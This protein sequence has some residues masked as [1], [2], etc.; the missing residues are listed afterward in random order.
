MS[1]VSGKYD[2]IVIGSGFGGSVAAATLT[3]G[4]AKVLLLERGPWRDTKPVRDAGIEDRKPLPY[5]RHFYTHALS[6]LAAPFTRGM[7]WRFNC[8]GLF[9]LHYSPDMSVLCSSGVGGGS[10]VYAA[11]NERPEV[12]AYWDNR[13]QGISAE[14][15]ELH[16]C[17]MIDKMGG[18]S[19]APGYQLPNATFDRYKESSEFTADS[20]LP[21]PVMAVRMNGNQE[22]YKSNSFLGSRN[23]SKATLDRVLLLPALEKGL[24]VAARHECLAI[25]QQTSGEYLL[26]VLDHKRN[27]RCFIRCGKVILSAGTL[28]TVRL[29]SRSRELGGL[30]GMPALGLGFGGNGD[31][32]AYWAV[33]DGAVDY[34]AGIPY[35][36]RF[37][38]RDSHTG[39]PMPGPDLTSYGF[40]GFSDI[41]IPDSIR[42]RLKRNLL[43]VSMGADK[44]DGVLE[45]NKGK[46]RSKYL[47]QNSAILSQ[48][49]ATFDEIARR[50]KKAVFYSKKRLITVHPL[51]GARLSDRPETGVVNAQGEIYG[52]P[53]LYVA[54]AAALPAAPG[55][56]PSMTISAWSRHVARGI[57]MGLNRTENVEPIQQ[58][59]DA[60]G[61]VA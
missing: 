5:G 60:D 24:T 27:R 33:N 30:G 51:G 43:V 14:G 22:D 52:N 4:G 18:K 47:Q 58:A 9:D 3:D 13:A 15:M 46:L 35:H 21:Q 40:N 7:G 10:H 48:I 23:G 19:P 31:M 41:P 29:L 59:I 38:L 45:W 39:K 20:D 28:N 53:G 26:E 57:L 11:M 34:T 36:G 56:P 2:V 1:T 8:N 16:Y 49:Y 17:W 25:W 50:S 32:P 37:A 44:A 6:R 54:D 12:A 42:A 61:K 55:G